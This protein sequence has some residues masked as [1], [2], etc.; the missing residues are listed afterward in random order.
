MMV[1]PM[2]VVAV[3][4]VMMVRHVS[5]KNVSNFQCYLVPENIVIPCVCLLNSILY[6]MFREYVSNNIRKYGRVNFICVL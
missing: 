3:A 5:L 1:M 6:Y 4:V 2:V